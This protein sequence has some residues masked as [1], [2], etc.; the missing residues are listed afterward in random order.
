MSKDRQSPE[1]NRPQKPWP[2]L[3]TRPQP[4]AERFAA[5]LRAAFGARVAP[6][7]S[8]LMAVEFLPFDLPATAFEALVLTSETGARAAAEQ[9]GLPR[10]AFC[11]GEQTAQVAREAGFE[12]LSA[13]GAAEDLAALITAHPDIGPMLYLHGEDRA[14]DLAALLPQRAIV[15]RIAYRQ[16]PQELTL[17]ARSLLACEGEV[18]LPLMSPRS[19]RLFLAA[20]AGA[21][22]IAARLRPVVISQNAY[23][24]LPEA[25]AKEARIAARP[26]AQAVISAIAELISLPAS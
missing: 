16:K 19:V 23:A 18:I 24:A 8:P 7:V 15:S 21:A 2:V 26:D 14:A 17:A 10:L 1:T 22:P 25:L 20:L 5:Q 4:A 12:A 6:L 11:V 9:G 13:G 3:I